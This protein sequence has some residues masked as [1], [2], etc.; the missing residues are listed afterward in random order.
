VSKSDYPDYKAQR[1]RKHRITV[2][3]NTFIITSNVDGQKRW[4]REVHHVRRHRSGSGADVCIYPNGGRKTSPTLASLWAHLGI[5][6]DTRWKECAADHPAFPASKS[7]K[8]SLDAADEARKNRAAADVLMAA[9]WSWVEG[10]SEHWAAPP[11][12]TV[13]LALWAMH[14]HGPDDVHAAPSKAAALEVANAIN[15][16]FARN[17]IKPYA[18]VVRW[19]GSAEEHSASVAAWEDQWEHGNGLIDSGKAVQ[20]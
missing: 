1:P 8:T 10:E 16:E 18:V 14:L 20:S 13:D 9:G 4:I 19:T 7:I 3:E 2:G 17:E 11:A 6:A 15:R 5:D 12:Q